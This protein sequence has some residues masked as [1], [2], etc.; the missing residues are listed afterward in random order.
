[1]LV[2]RRHETKALENQSLEPVILGLN[3]DSS[4]ESLDKQD[5]SLCTTMK[6]HVI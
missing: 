3:L 2:S 6:I 4:Q 1:M 5:M